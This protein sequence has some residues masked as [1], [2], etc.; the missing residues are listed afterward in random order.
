MFARHTATRMRGSGVVQSLKSLVSKLHPQLPLSPKESQRLLTALTSSFRKQLDEAH[1]RQAQD[2]D[3]RP[4]LDRFGPLNPGHHGLHTSSV[5]FADRHLASVLTNPLLAKTAAD[6]KPDAAY[7]KAKLEL[8]RNPDL[9]PILLLEEYQEQGTATI[10]LANLCLRTFQ[11]SLFDLS[12]DVRRQK[13]ANVKAGLRT[14]RWL[15]GSGFYASQSFV[16][17]RKF[18]GAMVSMLMEE[19]EEQLL[20]DWLRID[21]RHRFFP[22]TQNCTY[23]NQGPNLVFRW[24]DFMLRLLIMKHLDENDLASMNHVLDTYFRAVDIHLELK[25][26]FPNNHLPLNASANAIEGWI[27]RLR[28][29]KQVWDVQRYDK[30]INTLH[31][32]HSSGWDQHWLNFKIAKLQLT[33]PKRP[34][35]LPFYKCLKSSVVAAPGS[36]RARVWQLFTKGREYQSKKSGIEQSPYVLLVESARLL[37]SQG[38][39]EEAEWLVSEIRNLFPDEKHRVDKNMQQGFNPQKFNPPSHPLAPRIRP[40]LPPLAIS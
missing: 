9:D 26:E 17:D 34:T 14:L 22:T 1:P 35:A 19:G 29:E 32:I 18:M 28:H 33:H 3:V 12:N 10:P 25:P 16:Q 24:K 21:L 40:V 38:H 2:E 23:A 5:S 15:W 20:W 7:E 13:V 30:F 31:L 6:E 36:S 39:Q 4:K 37:Q 27:F 11:A 8:E